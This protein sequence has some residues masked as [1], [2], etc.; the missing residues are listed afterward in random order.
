MEPNES[1]SESEF[2]TTQ[3]KEKK[4][5]NISNKKQLESVYS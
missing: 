1:E 4:R 5:K 2:Y 3:Q